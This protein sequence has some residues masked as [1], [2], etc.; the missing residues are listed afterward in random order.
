V[1]RRK[2]DNSSISKTTL[3][4]IMKYIYIVL[5]TCLIN[6]LF[7]QS[8]LEV[9]GR[10]IDA[11]GNGVDLALVSLLNPTDSVFIKSEFTDQDGSFLLTNVELGSY[12]LQINLLG[13]KTYT[14]SI[15]LDSSEPKIEIPQIIL[16]EDS[17]LLDQVTIKG[18]I[19]FIERKI[20]R[21][22]I[23][24]DALIS[25]AGKNAL[26]VLEQ[27]P[28]LSVDNNGSLMLKG[29]SGVSVFINDK[30]SY[31]SGTELENYLRAL[32]AGSIKQIEI[33]ENPPA[34]YEAAGN[35]GVVNIIIKRNTLKGLHGNTS[36]GYRK[37]RYNGSNNSLILNYNK[38]KVSLFAN[39]YGGFYNSYQ[40]LFINRYYRNED[41]VRL[42]SFAQNSFNK[43]EGKYINAK[44]GMDYYLTDAT[45]MGI[46]YKNV[47]QPGER[48]VDNTSLISDSEDLLLQRVVADN[49]SSSSFTNGLVNFYITHDLDTLGSKISFDADYVKY[50]S[51]NEQVFKNFIFDNT[52]ELTYEDQID[53]EIPSTIKIYAA[54][55]D[56]SKPF[57]D[58]SRFEAGLKTALTQTDNEV[59]Y[60]TTIDGVTSPNYELSNRFLYDEWINSGY[61]N[62]N[63]SLGFIDIQ[64]GLRV[65]STRLE[66]D[67]LGNIEIQDTNF[68]RSYT[69]LFP[70]F[71]AS[72]KL[73]SSG[74][75]T[76]SFSYGRRIDRPYFQDLNPFVRPLDQFTFYGGNPNLLPTFSH[77]LSLTHSYKGVLNTSFSYSKTIDAI[78]ET[79]EIRDGIYYSR[80][81]N[82]SSSAS[83]T[84]SIDGSHAITPWYNFNGYF[85]I[86]HLTYDSQLYTEQLNSSGTYYY[87]SGNNTFQLGKGWKADF[88]G[89]YRSDLVAAQLLIKSYVAFNLGFQKKILNDRGNLK[90]S[91]NDIFHTRRGNGIINNL[92]LTDADWNSK[93]DSRNISLTFSLRFGKS[94]S[95]KQKYNSSGSDSEQRRVRN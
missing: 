39:V 58:G 82:I 64:T 46:S 88:S 32:P 24:P 20:D 60:T 11:E 90:L 41:N 79:L 52:E 78:N 38:D 53:G 44:I 33:M 1:I 16:E 8:P 75:N 54:K 30:P 69:S 15:V 26:E 31:L 93:Y 37:S 63:R 17:Q 10:I 12:I 68:T 36:I 85:E 5:F 34:K 13:Y 25:N 95:K 28:G 43:N 49:I 55:A 42:S 83:Y 9:T 51:N 45:A 65:E 74:N 70:T 61:L 7:A 67:Q 19:P 3:T 66:G 59:I 94:L 81:G 77:N 73:D 22:V 4:S 48:G 27:A 57:A 87:V 40:D 29:R 91:V 2:K 80:P 21:T 89:Q 23:T 6:S 92:R 50:N 72:T 18:K 47:N 14:N 56:Y 84:L 35:S 76:L 71:Y 86:G 62:Y